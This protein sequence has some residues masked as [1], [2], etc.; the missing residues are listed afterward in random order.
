[1]GNKASR[2]LSIYVIGPSSTGKTTLCDTLA[3]RLGL[4]EHAYV[5]EVA[6][7]VMKTK[8]YSRHTI[9]SLQM[10]EDIMDAHFHREDA[11]D[12]L[13][14]PICLFDRSALDP[15]VYAILTSKDSE[16]AK[17]RQAILVGSERFQKVLQKYRAENSIVI[18]LTPV[19]EWLV[20]DG[21]R[22]LESQNECVMIFRKLL[23]DLRVDYYE[24][25][26][27]IKFIQERV[28]AVMGLGRF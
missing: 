14:V 12:A 28:V 16:E 22:S 8:G 9:A 11:L 4:P 21:V 10:Q 6:R 13:E 7:D 1:M 19:P 18:L 20:D 17:A 26:A 27:E 24:L 3:K 23:K 25:G 5:T 15:I 2:P